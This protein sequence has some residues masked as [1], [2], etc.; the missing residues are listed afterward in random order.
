MFKRQLGPL[1]YSPVLI[2]ASSIHHTNVTDRLT[3]KDIIIAYNA[4]KNTAA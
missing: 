1:S 3:D 4:Q 2:A